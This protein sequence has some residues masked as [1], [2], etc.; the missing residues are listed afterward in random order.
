MSRLNFKKDL[1]IENCNNVRFKKYRATSIVAGIEPKKQK[2]P[3]WS[4]W[5]EADINA[6]KWEVGGKAKETKVG[7]SPS[8][9]VSL[10]K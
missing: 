1:K 10:F 5:M 9:P 3:L 4:E 2:L 6:E 7:K 8:A